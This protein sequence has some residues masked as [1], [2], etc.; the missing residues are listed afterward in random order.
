MN[1]P[2]GTK[3][4]YG[5]K[6]L[7]REYVF[8]VIKEVSKLN[9][10][11]QIETPIFEHKEIFVK[12]IGKTTDIVS[13]EMYVFK[14]K[15]E[16][17]LVLKPEGTASVMRAIVENKL[18]TKKLPLK[19]F[20]I[21]PNFRYER[22]QK[23]RQRQF[24]QF[25]IEMLS[26]PNPI[27]DAE[28]ILFAK[29]ILDTL[30]INYKLLINSIGDKKI[31]DN[32]SK[33]LNKYFK[34]YKNELSE[35]SK[36]RLDI[37]PLRILDDKIDS[38]K[39]FVKNSPKINKFYDSKTKIYFQSLQNFLTQMGVKY[40][41]N[42]NLMRGIDYYSNVCFEFISISGKAG[43]QNTLIGGGRYSNLLKQFGGPNNLSGIGFGLGIERVINELDE[44]KIISLFSEKLDIYVINISKNNINL[45]AGIV[46]LLR[47]SGFSTEWN[48]KSQKISK[49]FQN[50]DIYNPKLQ[51]IAG[52]KEL[53]NQKVIV[54]KGN[55]QKLVKIDNLIDYIK[56]ELEYENIK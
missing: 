38:K 19:F 39:E 47:K 11:K 56:K 3:D 32:Y 37:N 27:I 35:V 44:N 7:L 51:I 22:P 16:R 42:N 28:I 2:K 17:E 18:F 9:N 43:S 4:Y 50:A 41:V 26:F 20:Y 25:G 21:T 23:G 15:K 52:D 6:Q 1:R 31:R 10:F 46:Y 5:N 55:L 29:T 40:E 24:T 36:K 49:G 33:E 54:K 48:I 53:K 8:D 34:K 14:D 12:S 45:V 13:K 30:N